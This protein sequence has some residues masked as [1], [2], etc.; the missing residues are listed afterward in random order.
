MLKIPFIS[1]NA[2]LD[3]FLEIRENYIFDINFKF[4]DRYWCIQSILQVTPE[5]KV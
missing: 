2:H 1:G 5:K 4:L 3:L